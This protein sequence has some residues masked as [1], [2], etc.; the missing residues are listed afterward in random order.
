MTD[1]RALA[2]AHAKARRRA[3]AETLA[4]TYPSGAT[5]TLEI[6]CGHG[7]YLSAYARQ[8]PDE[9]C[10]GV[11]LV[12]DRIRRA[13]RK[14]HRLGLAH[15]TFLK[16]DAYELLDLLPPEVRLRRIF[17]LY[18]DP[19]P[20]RRHHRHR[21]LQ[22]PM[23]DA[24]AARAPAGTDLCLRTDHDGFFSWA[25]ARIAEH[26]AW[27]LDSGAA[28]PFEHPTFF[29]QLLGNPNSLIA[30]RCRAEQAPK[31]NSAQIDG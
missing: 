6:G 5:L 2:E 30:R 4:C 25:R 17:V 22:P 21:L 10:L 13:N 3:L 26:T 18:P 24:L 7:H 31:A 20:K 11:D 15:L 12:S 29:Q 23:L 14:R 28:W 8:H 16:A 19:W 27:L 9:T 1:G